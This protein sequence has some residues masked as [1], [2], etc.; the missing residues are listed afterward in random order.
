MQLV[1]DYNAGTSASVKS[2]TAVYSRH[3]TVFLITSDRLGDGPDELGHLLMKNFIHT[4]LE[5][6][7]LPSRMLFMNSGVR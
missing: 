3:A 4:L 6:G 2:A 7:N 5:T 1:I